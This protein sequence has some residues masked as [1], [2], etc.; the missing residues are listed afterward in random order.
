M[1]LPPAVP[2]IAIGT[3]SLLTGLVLGWIVRARRLNNA[4]L[5]G[6]CGR[7]LPLE[8]RFRFH[9]RTVCESCSQRLRYLA[10]PRLGRIAVLIAVWGTGVAALV[11]MV[12]LHDREVRVWA[13]IFSVLV[14]AA[15]F[16]GALPAPHES[17]EHTA[18]TMRR[19]H[20]LLRRDPASRSS[21]QEP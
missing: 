7:L 9:G 19:L 18:A 4:D 21:G 17:H 20:S 10:I 2:L 15:L 14:V 13:P 3:A 12:A 16:V 8:H 1:S 6:S 11:A 5:C